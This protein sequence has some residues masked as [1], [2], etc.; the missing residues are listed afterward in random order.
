MTLPLIHTRVKPL[1]PSRFN[2][3][4]AEFAWARQRVERHRHLGGLAGQDGGLGIFGGGTSTPRVDV[5][6]DHRQYAGV[7]KCEGMAHLAVFL[8]DG[9]EVVDTLVILERGDILR[10]LLRRGGHRERRHENQYE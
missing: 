10:F 7:G 1:L 2:H 9:T 5:A 6:D 4:L 8:L 3:L